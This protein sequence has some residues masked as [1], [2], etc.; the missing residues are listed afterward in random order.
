MFYTLVRPTKSLTQRPSALHT[1][2][3]QQN[4]ALRP[5]LYWR[6]VSVK[7]CAMSGERCS[8]GMCTL[9]VNMPLSKSV[10]FLWFLEN[11]VLFRTIVANRRKKRIGI[12]RLSRGR[13]VNG[14]FHRLYY[15]L[16]KDSSRFFEFLRMSIKTFDYILEKIEHRIQKKATNFKKPISPIERLYLTLR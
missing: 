6:A 5:R 8:D 14:G 1:L 13:I 2:N 9:V 3:L 10:R 12:D 15:D 7:L 16:R 11:P 4:T